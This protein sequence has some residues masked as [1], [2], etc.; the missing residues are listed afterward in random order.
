MAIEALPQ[1]KEVAVIGVPDKALG[2]KVKAFI[3]LTEPGTLMEEDIK[4]YLSEKIAKYKMPEFVEFVT[5]L[6]RNP[7]GKILKKEL[8]RIEEENNK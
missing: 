7:T 6:P 4:T 8:K 5:D 3:I 1:V 2:E